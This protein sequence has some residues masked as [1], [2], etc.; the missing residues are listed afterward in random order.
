[1][2]DKGACVRTPMTLTSKDTAKAENFVAYKVCKT[3][4]P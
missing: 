2:A 4:A 1:M 3:G